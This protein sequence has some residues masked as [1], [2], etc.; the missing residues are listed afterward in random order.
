[1]KFVPH[2]I[3]VLSVLQI[4]DADLENRR[5]LQK[6]D[7][8]TGVIYSKDVYDPVKPGPKQKVGW[9]LFNFLLSLRLI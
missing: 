7:P 6:V 1:M 3:S 8:V 5:I 4:P 2:S 9:T